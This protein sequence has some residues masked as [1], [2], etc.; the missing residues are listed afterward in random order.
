M[1]LVR[2][3]WKPDRR[4]LRGFG[5]ICL[6]AFGAIGCWIRF[7]HTFMGFDVA[8]GAVAPVSYV[9]WSLAA[10]GL[11]LGLAAPTLLRPLYLGLTLV[12]LPIGFVVSHVIMALLFYGLFTPIGLI[13]RL[14]GRDPLER[15]FEREARSY[16]VPHETPR[17]VKRYY[18]QF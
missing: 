2:V 10:L 17:D 15:R 5:M 18:R 7:R 16:W 9:L 3:N 4:Q 13:F 8:P 11:L 1:A 14:I 6:V 12:S